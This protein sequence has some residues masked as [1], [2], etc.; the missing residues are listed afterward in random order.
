MKESVRM[1]VVLALVAIASAVVLSFVNNFTYEHI[2]SNRA[3]VL[4]G[5]IFAVLPG[6]VDVKVIEAGPQNIFD[7]DRSTLR[8]KPDSDSDP[9][10]LYQ[11][12]DEQ[13]D[14]VGFA[15]VGEAA[16]YGG[17]VKIMV[18][19]DHNTE[20]ISGLAVLEHA[21][22][23]NLGSKIEDESFRK[24]FVGKGLNDPI[25][26]GQDIDKITGATVSSVAVTE[27][28]RADYALAL[29]AYKEAVLN[30]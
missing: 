14:P 29:E 2:Q 6:A 13:G 30:D 17:I 21:E 7:D 26:V 16:G 28:V 1:V 20:L 8:N 27:A 9:L 4:H 5:S 18:G 25:A 12:L 22:T 11:G 23:P 3:R 19:V 15:Y 10:L 24:Q